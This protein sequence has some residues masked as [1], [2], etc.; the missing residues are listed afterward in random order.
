[1]ILKILNSKKALSTLLVGLI[2]ALVLLAIT[3]PL[4]ANNRNVAEN[5]IEGVFNCKNPLGWNGKCIP[6]YES[7]AKYKLK[8]WSNLPI[9]ENACY[10]KSNPDTKDLKCCMYT[11]D[12]SKEMFMLVEPKGE[13]K[14]AVYL[15]VGDGSTK[16]FYTGGS[17]NE[18]VEAKLTLYNIKNNYLLIAS[19]GHCSIASSTHGSPDCFFT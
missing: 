11:E 5:T 16:V 18:K 2:I 7:C 14:G 1:M 15:K 19:T 10:D 4:I 8:D 3:V 6:A 13:E 12:P 17:L 9:Y